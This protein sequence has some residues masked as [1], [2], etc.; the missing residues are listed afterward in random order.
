MLYVCYTGPAQQASMTMMFS[1]GKK[2]SSVP[3]SGGVKS[4]VWD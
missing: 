1:F 2:A 4:K 3:S